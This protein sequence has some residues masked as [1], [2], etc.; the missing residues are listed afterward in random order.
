M[1]STILTVEAAAALLQLHPK[2][3][4]RFIRE[5]RLRATRVGRSYRVLRSDI[6]AF[7]G[8]E[9]TPTAQLARVTSIVDIEAVDAALMQRLSALLL[10]SA[11]GGVAAD[12]PISLDLAHDPARR[13]L[14]VIIQA[15]PADAAA[16]LRLIDAC[17]TNPA[18]LGRITTGGSST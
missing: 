14:K 18:S 5:G 4:L 9:P 1:T 12:P 3:V 6:E 16:L 7:A 10:G 11:Q 8:A 15:S 13:S 2:T 17:L